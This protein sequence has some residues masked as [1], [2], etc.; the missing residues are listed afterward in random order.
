MRKPIAL[1]KQSKMH[2]NV[3]MIN[4]PNGTNATW[5][6]KSYVCPK[7]TIELIPITSEIAG[8]YSYQNLLLKPS[9]LAITVGSAATDMTNRAIH[10]LSNNINRLNILRNNTFQAINMISGA[11]NTATNFSAATMLDLKQIAFDMTMPDIRAAKLPKVTVTGTVLN[12]LFSMPM[13]INLSKPADMIHQLVAGLVRSIV[14]KIFKQ[15]EQAQFIPSEGQL[16]PEAPTKE[17]Q[18]ILETDKDVIDSVSLSAITIS[19]VFTAFLINQNV[20]YNAHPF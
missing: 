20:A 16:Y 17:F 4:H 3:K 10:S 9:S 5:I 18:K 15:T 11:V 7:V 13:Q 2:K 1:V 8:L 19:P 12:N 14:S 6:Q